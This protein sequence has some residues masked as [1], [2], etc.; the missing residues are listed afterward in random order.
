MMQE[1]AS[2]VHYTTLLTPASFRPK[3]R[4][5]YRSPTQSLHQPLIDIKAAILGLFSLT[6]PERLD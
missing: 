4:A 1:Q 3:K 6:V 2:A 5:G